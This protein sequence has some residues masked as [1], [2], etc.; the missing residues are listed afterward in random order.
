MSKRHMIETLLASYEH[1]IRAGD[2]EEC[3]NQFSRWM[4][5]VGIAL[6]GAGLANE[7]LLWER[8]KGEVEFFDDDDSFPAQAESMK[9]VLVGFL[10]NLTEPEQF[11]DPERLEQLRGISSS[12]FS[13][14]KLIELCEELNICFANAC[15]LAVPML[16]RG[17]LDHVPP[18]FGYCTFAEVA[19]NYG[20]G[21]SIKQSMQR[22]EN[23]LRSI[24]DAHLHQPIRKIESLPNKTQVNF[25][26]DV[27]VLLAEAVRQL[28]VHQGGTK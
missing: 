15:Y 17:L 28:V 12:Q 22:L 4:Q 19:N 3:A 23:S 1:A 24:A 5:R 13:L 18:I 7:H 8:A 26:N 6:E 25:S 27:D 20:A 14:V 21:K 11:V 16:T 10:A 9:A 2:S